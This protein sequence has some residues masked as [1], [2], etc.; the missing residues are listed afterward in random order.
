MNQLSEELVQTS[1]RGKKNKWNDKGSVGKYC[2]M[3]TEVN[4]QISK[5]ENESISFGKQDDI[6]NEKRLVTK[7]LRSVIEKYVL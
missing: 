7:L 6:V 4:D 5:V 1:I 2:D 3:L